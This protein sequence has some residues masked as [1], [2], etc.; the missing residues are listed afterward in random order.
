MEFDW[1]ET[2]RKAN[3]QKHGI[4]F[5]GIDW[6]FDDETVTVLDDRFDYGEQRFVTFGIL[7][8]RVI[9]VAHTETEEIIRIISARKAT[10]NEEENY[11]KTIRD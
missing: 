4:D 6:L 11:S 8:G 5:V 3:L 2:K 10:R 9:A 7:E 1:D